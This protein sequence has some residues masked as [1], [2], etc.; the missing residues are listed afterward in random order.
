MTQRMADTIAHVHIVIVEGAYNLM[1][2]TYILIR[3]QCMCHMGSTM[4]A[5]VSARIKMRA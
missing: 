1:H 2:F 3:V 5:V 4:D